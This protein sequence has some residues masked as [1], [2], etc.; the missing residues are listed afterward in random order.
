MSKEEDFSKFAQQALRKSRKGVFEQLL[1]QHLIA[2]TFNTQPS[3][4]ISHICAASM[5]MKEKDVPDLD[6]EELGN[7]YK[8]NVSLSSPRKIRTN[9]FGTFL[10]RVV[11]G[12]KTSKENYERLI[13]PW[14]PDLNFSYFPDY[15]TV[16]RQKRIKVRCHNCNHTL[17]DCPLEEVGKNK[18]Y[19][20]WILLTEKYGKEK[21]EVWRDPNYFNLQDPMGCY[22]ERKKTVP[23]CPKCGTEVTSLTPDEFQGVMTNPRH[24]FFFEASQYLTSDGYQK[25]TNQFTNWAIPLVQHAKTL[26]SRLVTPQTYSDMLRIL[27][28]EREGEPVESVMGS[29]E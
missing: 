7:I 9:R 16:H 21:I 10:Y 4:I 19:Q 18:T 14:K 5:M 26:L 27:G 22:K 25:L 3:K 24:G 15:V 2:G 1:T 20:L 8:V 29:R 12:F 23:Y 11:W 6:L 28:E 13:V 17:L